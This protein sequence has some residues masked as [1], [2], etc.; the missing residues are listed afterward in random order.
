MSQSDTCEGEFQAEFKFEIS[1]LFSDLISSSD[2]RRSN[3]ARR[4]KANKQISLADFESDFQNII[5]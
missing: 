2:S 1:E 4:K 5:F 3:I